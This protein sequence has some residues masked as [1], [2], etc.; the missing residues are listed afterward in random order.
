[1]GAIRVLIVDDSP[2]MVQNVQK[3]LHF[4]PDIQVIGAAGN[5][6]E[7]FARVASFRPDVVLMDINLRGRFDGLQATQ[8]ITQRWQTCVVMMSVQREP[9]YITRSMELGALGYLTKPFT[10]DEL[11]N[12]IRTAYSRFMSLKRVGYEEALQEVSQNRSYASPVPPQPAA[13]QSLRQIITIY[14]PKGGCGRSTLAVNLAIA[15]RRETNRSVVLVDASL[16]AGDLHVLL[17]MNPSSSIEDLRQGVGS[18]EYDQVRGA[19]AFHEDS[20]VGLV[21]APMSI[22]AAARFTAEAMKAVLVELSD[23]FDYL[24]V[25]TDTTYS[26][27]T[28]TALEM[29]TLVMVVTT[30]EVTTINR[31]GQFFEIAERLDGVVPKIHLICNRVDPMYGIKVH[32]VAARFNQKFLAE[33]PEDAR[34]A[35][36]ALN[37]GVP[38]ILSQKNAP[39]TKAIE[40]MATGVAKVLNTAAGAESRVT[41]NLSGPRS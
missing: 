36:A 7:A 23:H 10:G 33:I 8:F 11:V 12:K 26:D 19:V 2:D 6:E 27:Y 13:S 25:D 20:G 24:I 15:L 34:V 28:L 31:I 9:E 18:L 22:D 16:A 37:R 14:S 3:L 32:H 40:K 38:F 5:A 21:R 29:A 41:R 1:M 30:Q 35:A 4:A 17:N 39:I